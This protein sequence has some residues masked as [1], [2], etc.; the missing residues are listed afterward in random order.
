MFCV[1]TLRPLLWLLR[2]NEGVLVLP[3]WQASFLLATSDLCLLG[4]LFAALGGGDGSSG[5]AAGG[6]SSKGGKSVDAQ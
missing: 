4:I 1:Q 5:V 2:D 6:G 3:R